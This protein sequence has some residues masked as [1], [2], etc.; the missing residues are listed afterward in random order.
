MYG[1]YGTDARACS[2]HVFLWRTDGCVIA[3]DYFAQLGEEEEARINDA[4]KSQASNV[5]IVT[6]PQYAFTSQPNA[7]S[8]PQ[9]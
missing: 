6:Q 4:E 8:A 7:Y 5:T 2:H 9:Y 1:S 3:Y